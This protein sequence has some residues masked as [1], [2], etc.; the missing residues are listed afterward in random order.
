MDAVSSRRII[1]QMSARERH[2]HVFEA[3]VPGRETPE[4]QPMLSQALQNCRQRHVWLGDR[5]RVM[6]RF[7]SN[8]GYSRKLAQGV[9]RVEECL[10]AL[11][12]S[13]HHREIDHM[14][15]AQAG[16]QLARRAERDNLSMIYDGYAIAQ[17]LG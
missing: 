6:I 2:E 5:K 14:L 11:W 12:L 13:V 1:A 16:D 7:P 15:S 4:I 9:G 10:G 3:C 17:P 8:G